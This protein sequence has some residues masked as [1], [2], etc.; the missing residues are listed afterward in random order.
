MVLSQALQLNIPSPIQEVHHPIF[1]NHQVK[2]YVKRE[3]LIHKTIS[4]N[5]WRK[6]KYHIHHVIDK[7]FEGVLSFGGTFSNHIHALS[8]ACGEVGIKSIFYIRGEIDPANPTIKSLVRNGSVIYGIDRIKFKSRNEASFIN[9]FKKEHPGYFIIPEGGSSPL[10]RKGVEEMCDEMGRYDY[11]AI[12]SGTGCTGGCMINKLGKTNGII[13]VYPALKGDFTAH[14]IK[15]WIIKDDVKY[16]LI[17]D[18]HFGGYGKINKRLID[19]INEFTAISGIP[20]DP[21]YNG[22]LVY[23]L[24]ERI[25]VGVYPPGSSILWIHTGGLQGISGFNYRW[26]GK[27]FIKAID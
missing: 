27:Y 6:L 10:A 11:I 3:D 1:K 14:D 16:Q 9:S 8:Y 12:A 21:I 25:S 20:I 17:T 22:K 7:K 13:E 18:Y 19:F 15:K 24:L 4:G 5:K 26:K 2:V 23:G